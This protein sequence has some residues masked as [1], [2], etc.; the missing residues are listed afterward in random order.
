[1]SGFQAAVVDPGQQTVWQSLFIQSAE[2]ILVAAVGLSRLP[3]YFTW[4]SY[5]SLVDYRR[6]QRLKPCKHSE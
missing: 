2:K 3:K 5:F 4:Y 6:D 1:M